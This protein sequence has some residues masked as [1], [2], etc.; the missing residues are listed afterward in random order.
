VN[1]TAGV[2]EPNAATVDLGPGGEMQAYLFTAAP[3]GTA[4]VLVDV[5]G[6][7]IGHTHDDRYYTKSGADSRFAQLAPWRIDVAPSDMSTQPGGP[8]YSIHDGR[9][10]AMGMGFGD[11]DRCCIVVFGFRLPDQYV[12]GSPVVLDI[13]WSPASIATLNPVGCSFIFSSYLPRVSRSG[14]PM[15]VV[16]TSWSDGSP[17]FTV[18]DDALNNLVASTKRLQL[19]STDLRPGDQLHVFLTR[20]QADIGDSCEGVASVHAITVSE[21]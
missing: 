17:A 13:D 8:I 9:L 11:D 5:V 19:E 16:D 7:T 20:L 4:D 3:G 1:F 12:D 14:A 6:Y 18:T 10:G 21:G 2:I 15:F